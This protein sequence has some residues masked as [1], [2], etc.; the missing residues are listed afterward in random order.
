MGMGRGHDVRT[1][2]VHS[3]MDGECRRVDRSVPDDDF[4]GVAHENQVGDADMAEAHGEGVHPEVIG[5]F[6]VACRDV[7]GDTLGEAEATEQPQRAGQLL[8]AVQPL[9]LH[10]GEFGGRWRPEIAGRSRNCVG[11]SLIHR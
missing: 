1:R 3:G 4:A 2:C 11:K 8:L 6:R 5:Q 10:G 9:L 7:A